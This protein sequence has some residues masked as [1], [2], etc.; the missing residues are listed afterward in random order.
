MPY[1]LSM[2]VFSCPY[3]SYMSCQSVK[4]YDRIVKVKRDLEVDI[5]KIH[6]F[7]LY[8]LGKY[9]K[10]ETQDYELEEGFAEECFSLGFEM[11]CGK[12]FESVHGSA[13]LQTAEELK[14]IIDSVKDAHI[15]GNAVFSQWRYF[16]HWACSALDREWFVVALSRLTKLT[17]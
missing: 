16:T 14:R 3:G 1:N 15:L 13:A 4:E 11:D 12:S 10:P 9:E 2:N 8:W 17:E 5:K 7:S 6:E